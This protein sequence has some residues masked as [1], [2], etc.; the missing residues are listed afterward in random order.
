MRRFKEPRSLAALALSQRKC[1]CPCRSYSAGIGRGRG[2]GDSSAQSEDN[3]S[4]SIPGRGRGRGGG[5][6]F[7]KPSFLGAEKIEQ[8]EEEE[9]EEKTSFANVG[10]GQTPIPSPSARRSSPLQRRAH[11]DDNDDAFVERKGAPM[12]SRMP[13]L[14]LQFSGFGRGKV[15]QETSFRSSE[16]LLSSDQGR[17]ISKWSKW[18]EKTVKIDLKEGASPEELRLMGDAE[19]PINVL[20]HPTPTPVM[21]SK[22]MDRAQHGSGNTFSLLYQNN[23]EK[24]AVMCD[25]SQKITK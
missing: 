17:I 2:F 4:Q 13:S 9:E 8:K 15:V 18:D 5:G 25:Q 7:F 11:D 10:P 1:P 24:T 23:L 19:A 6:G 12:S 3:P 14:G 21:Q 16:E 22:R 20:R